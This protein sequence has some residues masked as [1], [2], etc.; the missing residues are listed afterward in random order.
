M[1]IVLK[2]VKTGEADRILT[3]LTQKLGIITASAKNSMRIKSKL[4]ASTSMFCYSE[5]TLFEGKSMYIIDDA[6]CNKIFYNINDTVEGLALAMYFGELTCAVT[7][8]GQEAT[9]QLS[10][11]LN[12]LHCINEKKYP[13]KLI[14][15]VYELRT[16]T[17]VGLMPNL[18]A[19]DE[20]ARFDGV[21]FYFDVVNA[22]ILCDECAKKRGLVSNISPSVLAAMRH[23]VFCEPKKLFSFTMNEKSIQ[24]LY[25]IVEYYSITQLEK[26]LK[27][28]DFLKSVF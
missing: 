17:N 26:H 28:L 4:L 8:Q 21:S 12:C 3:I 19:C 6:D 22:D 11:L 9:E 23:I 15:A 24:M 13:L 2:E 27:T 1:G 7:P 16:L 20:C 18:V 25:E 14:K 5:L 10:L